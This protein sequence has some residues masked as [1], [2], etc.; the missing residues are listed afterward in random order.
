V[1][2]TD[3]N[4][5]LE[6]L[7]AA[8]NEMCRKH[9]GVDFTGRINV[10]KRR[11]KY[12]NGVFKR[13]GGDNWIEFSAPRNAGRSREEVLGVL[14]HELVHWRLFKTGVP[15]DDRDPEFVEECL[16]VG[17]PISGTKYA[18]DAHSRYVNG[19]ERSVRDEATP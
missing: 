14:L 12:W 15:F 2:K 18:K 4:L 9:W 17:A 11:W 16:R 1:T 6:E 7:Y 5:T 3:G 19:K 8:A 13:R 10:I